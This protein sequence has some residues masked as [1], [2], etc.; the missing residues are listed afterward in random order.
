MQN[1]APF[2]QY[3]QFF[4]QQVI[5]KEDLGDFVLVCLTLYNETAFQQFPWVVSTISLPPQRIPFFDFNMK[6]KGQQ[7]FDNLK[8]FILLLK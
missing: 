5:P 7:W 1:L 4:H 3:F 8:M 2:A 6:D